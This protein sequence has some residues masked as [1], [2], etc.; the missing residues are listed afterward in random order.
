[1]PKPFQVDAITDKGL[2]VEAKVLRWQ[3]TA[4]VAVP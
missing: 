2:Q 3:F 4:P 1:L